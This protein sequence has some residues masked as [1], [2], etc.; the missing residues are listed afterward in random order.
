M[1]RYD[2]AQEAA[3]VYAKA[4]YY[5]NLKTKWPSSID[6]IL[7]KFI[8]RYGPKQQLFDPKIRDPL[9]S[10]IRSILIQNGIKIP[11]DLVHAISSKLR[12]KRGTIKKS[13]ASL[14]NLNDLSEIPDQPLI[15]D[16]NV[17]SGY[18]GVQFDCN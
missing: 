18:Q 6:D 17:K 3:L 8:L 4:K 1:G 15:V 14:I 2:M 9:V 5:M 13:S 10:E 16:E 7:D 11:K 12:E